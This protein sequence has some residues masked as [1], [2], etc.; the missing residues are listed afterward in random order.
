MNTASGAPVPKPRQPL[1]RGEGSC[2]GGGA[3]RDSA[4][5]WEKHPEALEHGR[6]GEASQGVKTWAGVGGRVAFD[7]CVYSATLGGSRGTQSLVTRVGFAAPRH[8]RS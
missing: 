4:G 2:G 5:S 8:V 1:L 7:L 3:P 6:L